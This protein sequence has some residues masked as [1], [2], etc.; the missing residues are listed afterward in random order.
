MLRSVR[1]ADVFAITDGRAG[2][3]R[4]WLFDLKSKTVLLREICEEA[5]VRQSQADRVELISGEAKWMKSS[6]PV[7]LEPVELFYKRYAIDNIPQN[8][9]D[10]DKRFEPLNL[11]ELSD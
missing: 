9:F 8:L 10:A 6:M 5:F 2:K 4:E 3:V 11:I 7:E 1:S